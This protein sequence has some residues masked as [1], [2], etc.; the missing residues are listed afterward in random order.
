MLKRSFLQPFALPFAALAAFA[1]VFS[2]T[3]CQSTQL[4]PL[5]VSLPT[6][7]APTQPPQPARLVVVDQRPQHHALRLHHKKKPAQFATLEQPVTTLIRQQLAPYFQH[8]GDHSLLLQLTVDQGLCVAE[9]SFSRHNMNCAFVLDVV[10][11]LPSSAWTKTY[12]AKRSREGK[13]SLKP[14]YVQTD[15]AFV[16]NNAL[17][18][19]INDPTFQAWLE[20]NK[21]DKP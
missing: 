2:L 20:Q 16:L 17:Q 11:R 10:A 7:A 18:E 6:S 21:Q 9:E 3:G 12:T 19:F 15:I 4:A 13:F 5:Q 8:Q 14:D 1:A